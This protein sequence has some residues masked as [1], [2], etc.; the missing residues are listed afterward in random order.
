[1]SDLLLSDGINVGGI[2]DVGD[3]DVDFVEGC[4]VHFE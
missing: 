2:E 3:S 1:M 4:R